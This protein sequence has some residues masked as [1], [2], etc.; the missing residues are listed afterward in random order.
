[1]WVQSVFVYEAFIELLE[2]ARQRRPALDVRYSVMSAVTRNLSAFHIFQ[3]SNQ[4]LDIKKILNLYLH[5][6]PYKNCAKYSK[7][8]VA[9]HVYS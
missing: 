9:F 5:S 4:D 8:V 3:V 1:M 2:E 7:E 6:W